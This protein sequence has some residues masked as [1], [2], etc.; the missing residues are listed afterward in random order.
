V[1]QALTI[2]DGYGQ[3]NPH[4]DPASIEPAVVSTERSRRNRVSVDGSSLR[5]QFDVPLPN[6]HFRTR[7]APT[8]TC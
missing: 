2:A 6:V 3:L 5:L 7:T 8:V 4:V 1:G